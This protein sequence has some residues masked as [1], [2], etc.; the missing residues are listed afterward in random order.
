MTDP[1]S[2]QF[3]LLIVGGGITGLAAA[4]ALLEQAQTQGRSLRL[5]LVEAAPRLGGVIQ[6]ESRAGFLLEAG[7]DSFVNNT[8]EAV[9]LSTRLGL[10]EELTGANPA[11]R[12]SFVVRQDRLVPIPDGFS[13]IGPS[14]LLPFA[15]SPLLSPQGKV[16]AAL[17]AVIP[18]RPVNRRP[19][20]GDESVASFVRRRFGGELFDRLAGP[21]VRGIGSGDPENLS[22]RILLPQFLEME[23]Q[24]GSILRGLHALGR[25]KKAA[26]KNSAGPRYGL[27]VSF[28][29]GMQTLVD[30]LGKR[31]P[32]ESIRLGARAQSIERGP[33]GKG[34]RV[35]MADGQ[36][37]DAHAL[38][39]TLPPFGIAQLLR[40]L[41]PALADAFK[42]IPSASWATVNLAF[43]ATDVSHP[44]DGFG[45]VVPAS[46]D[47]RLTGCTFSHVKFPGRAPAEHVL[48]RAFIPYEGTTDAASPSD[49]AL[50]DTACRELNRL[51][52]LAGEPCF[53][54]VRRMSQ[55]L[56]KFHVGHPD[57]IA[58]IQES[59]RRHRG[60]VVA[61]NAYEGHGVTQCIKSG[62]KAAASLLDLV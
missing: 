41:D 1:Q 37:L 52:G 26:E 31:L 60:L 20:N 8:P 32:P 18:K 43:R 11:C 51:V 33:N 35:Q 55:S 22:M 61:G 19:A 14:R 6:T 12:K 58:Q 56:P 54:V 39:L 45:F 17:E 4:E 2:S 16:R 47:F 13:L 36:A 30:R 42:Q 24:H 53:A 50:Q 3:H 23:A 21:L 57:R 38:C 25:K 7:P 28:R 15:L 5:T 27:F 9:E 29:E 34:W 40:G 44:L 59:L 62:R 49:Q 48:F 10:S 46:E